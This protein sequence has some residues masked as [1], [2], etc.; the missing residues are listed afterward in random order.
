MDSLIYSLNVIVPIFVVVAVGYYLR[1]F[2]KPDDRF[3]GTLNKLLFYVGLSC[4]VF[5]NIYDADLK[6]VF[7]LRLIGFCLVFVCIEVLLLFIIVPRLVKERKSVGAIIQA[8]F[9]SNFLLLGYPL[10]INMFGPVGAQPVALM[11][12]F[13]IFIY[14]IFAVLCLTVFS[15]AK[16]KLTLTDFLRVLKEI[17]TNPLVVASIL[18]VIVKLM[19][20]TIPYTIYKPVSD[21]ALIAS[22]LA[23][24]LLGMQLD[25]KHMAGNLRLSLPTAVVRLLIVPILA[26]SAAVWFGFC[27]NELGAIFV[28][29]ASATAVSSYIMA[30]TLG[31]DYKL[32]GELVILTTLLCP[33]TLFIGIFVLKSL[34]LI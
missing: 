31:S 18:A 33:F 34:D 16:K 12:P 29:F 27:G 23:L 1:Y 15:E 11:L 14:N 8:S 3:I 30:Y 4:L 17:F 26:V 2:L 22:P 13:I 32:A 25:F 9:R 21:M 20:F 5:C 24:L 6:S 10:A 28:L 7:N 19:T